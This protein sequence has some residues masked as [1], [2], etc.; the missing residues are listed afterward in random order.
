MEEERGSSGSQDNP[1][2]TQVTYIESTVTNNNFTFGASSSVPNITINV[3]AS[4]PGANK[5]SAEDGNG[6]ENNTGREDPPA[7]ST[8]A[9]KRARTDLL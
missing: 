6:D 7:L 3:T 8:R 2:A 5:R 1:A 9:R 4:P